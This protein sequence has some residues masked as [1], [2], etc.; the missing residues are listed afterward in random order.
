MSKALPL[1]ERLIE[2]WTTFVKL[3]KFA[4]VAG[5]LKKGLEKL[6]KWYNKTDES[7]TYFICLALEP[8][9]K[10]EYCKMKWD[11]ELYDDGVNSFKKVFE[12]YRARVQSTPESLPTQAHDNLEDVNPVPARRGY[13]ASW[14]QDAIK[15]R[16]HVE[17]TARNP[18]QEFNDYLNAPLEA[19]VDD[20][21]AWWG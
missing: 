14:L 16:V 6:Q 18:Y 12:A 8:S 7:D 11:T 20:P 1:L 19:G 4:R 2:T 9:V 15:S 5:A 17:L 13:G 21:V 3:P 10:L